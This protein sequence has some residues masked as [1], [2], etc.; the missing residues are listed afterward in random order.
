MKIN[1][2]KEFTLLEDHSNDCMD[3]LKVNNVNNEKDNIDTW[4]NFK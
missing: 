2:K 3:I 4:E 1:D